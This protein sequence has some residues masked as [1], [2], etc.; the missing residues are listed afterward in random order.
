[1]NQAP[2][3]LIDRLLIRKVLRNVGRKQHEIRSRSKA[4]HIFAADPAIQFRQVI[5][6]PQFV[7][8]N[9]FLS[10]FLHIVLARAPSSFA[11]VIILMFSSRSACATINTRPAF[12][13]PTVMNRRSAIEWSGSGYVSASGSPNTVAASRNEI[14]CFR[15]FRR[16]LPGSHSKFTIPVYSALTHG[17][18]HVRVAASLFQRCLPF[19]P[20]SHANGGSLFSG[21]VLSTH[22]PLFTSDGF[23]DR[24][25]KTQSSERYWQDFKSFVL[26]IPIHFRR[27][28]VLDGRRPGLCTP[29]TLPPFG[30]ESS[31]DGTRGTSLWLHKSSA[32]FRS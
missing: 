32:E 4:L 29:P 18:N 17:S 15:R 13:I 12:D 2:Q 6:S 11:R 21:S 28:G 19:A 1:M 5:L 14:R 30:G 27:Q 9:S 20:L 26:A 22:R 24:L 3:G 25:K 23:A 8:P 31:I 7:P 10:F 16:A